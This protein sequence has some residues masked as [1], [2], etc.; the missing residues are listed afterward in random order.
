MIQKVKLTTREGKKL[1][2]AELLLLRIFI[3]V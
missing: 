2:A 3:L 1:W